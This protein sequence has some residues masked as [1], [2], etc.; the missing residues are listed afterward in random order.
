VKKYFL[1]FLLLT[2]LADAREQVVTSC[3]GKYSTKIIGRSEMLVE[4][5]GRKLGAV[6]VDHGIAGGVFDSTGELLVVYGVP[7]KVD[8]RSP[9]AEYLSIY[10][11]KPV[12]HMIMKRTY[13]G[14]V[15]EVA[16]GADSNLI[17]VSSRF[18]FDILD[19]KTMKIKSFDPMSEPPFS[20]Q[21]CEN[22]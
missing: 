10:R 5:A 2:C 12:P 19:V 9:Q 4:H 15:Y 8:I 21:Q 17:F 6:K 13:G 20:R 16:F 7:N 18:G 14:G 11:L 22:N 1:L 3:D